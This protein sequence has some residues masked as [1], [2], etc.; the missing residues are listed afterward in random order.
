LSYLC[1]DDLCAL[2]R[3]ASEVSGIS[4]VMDTDR[5]E[6]AKILGSN[7]TVSPRARI[8]NLN[9]EALIRSKALLAS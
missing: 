5:E 3:E 7:R 6:A 1:R 4:Y 8:M 9:I 2:T